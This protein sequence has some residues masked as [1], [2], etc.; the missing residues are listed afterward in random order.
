MD[1]GQTNLA[2]LYIRF[3]DL[4]PRVSGKS[5]TVRSLEIA[6]LNQSHRGIWISLEM[7]GLRHQISH[8][9]F[10]PGAPFDCA[11]AIVWSRGL[12]P[13]PPIKGRP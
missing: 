1:I 9:F 5:P 2:V 8:Q 3:F 12:F 13:L 4:T 6:E 10:I 7:S 11:E